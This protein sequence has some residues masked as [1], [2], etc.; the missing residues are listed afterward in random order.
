MAAGHK[1]GRM[2]SQVTYNC[3]QCQ[4]TGY[5]IKTIMVPEYDL[6]TPVEFAVQCPKCIGKRRVFDDTGIP[7]CKLR[8]NG[9]P[10]PLL[11]NGYSIFNGTKYR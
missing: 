10:V 9:M 8:S 2:F 3:E 11:R 7:E 6:K 5:I 4:D 1:P